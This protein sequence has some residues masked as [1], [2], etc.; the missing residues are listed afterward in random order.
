MLCD[1]GLNEVQPMPS[2]DDA[3]NGCGKPL[4]GVEGEVSSRLTSLG[5]EAKRMTPWLAF[6][7]SAHAKRLHKP[8]CVTAL[9]ISGI[10]FLGLTPIQ[11]GDHH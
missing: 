5:S 3:A 6:F 7:D 9:E 4:G 11:N 1:V 8:W 2:Y 10:I